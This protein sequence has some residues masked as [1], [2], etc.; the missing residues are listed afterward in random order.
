[1][2][3]KQSPSS[4]P[5]LSALQ[6][7]CPAR[8]CS[9]RCHAAPLYGKIRP[10]QA[11]SQALSVPPLETEAHTSSSLS[12][13]PFQEAIHSVLRHHL[14]SD[15]GL[16]SFC[17]F[18]QYIILSAIL[19][20][21]V[22]S[23]RLAVNCFSVDTWPHGDMS[24]FCPRLRG[25]LTAALELCKSLWWA[26]PECLWTSS[27][28]AHPRTENILLLQYMFIVLDD[29][30]NSESAVVQAN[31]TSH[32][33]AAQSVV[34]MFASCSKVG[35]PEVSWVTAKAGHCQSAHW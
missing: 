17:P 3:Y 22:L 6:Y 8:R 9:L 1:L 4:L 14:T 23:K 10:P 26:S 5:P 18:A 12:T 27:A 19:A 20:T 21:I 31:Y 30:R 29:A 2:L 11:W 33:W 25:E 35:F 28:T 16:E 13:I 32:P 34:D 24:S 15:C 7:R